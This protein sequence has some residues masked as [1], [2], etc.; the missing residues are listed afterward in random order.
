MVFPKKTVYSYSAPISTKKIVPLDLNPFIFS[1]G[2][3]I[4]DTTKKWKGPKIF[5]IYFCVFFVCSG[6][7]FI[8]GRG[9]GQVLLNFT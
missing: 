3:I 5:D 2:S 7:S 6:Q 8:S 9:P 1:W 4:A